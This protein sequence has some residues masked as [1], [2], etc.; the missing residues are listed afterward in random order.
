MLSGLGYNS[1]FALIIP[2][3]SD[4]MESKEV[5]SESV[6]HNKFLSAIRLELSQLSP[7]YFALVM[8]TGIVSIAAHLIGFTEIAQLLFK[9]NIVAYLLLV[10][11]FILRFIFFNNQF[12]RGL[13]SHQKSPG[14]FT[15][16]AGS[17]VLG[18]QFVLLSGNYNIALLLYYFAF[19]F[20]L[21]FIYYFFTVITIKRN[22][23]TLNKGLNGLW[24]LIV[25]S[26]QSLSILGIE[27][28]KYLFFSAEISFFLSLAL[29]LLGCLFYVIIISMIV[30]RLSFFPIQAEDFAPPYWISM[31]AVAITTLAGTSLMLN[32]EASLFLAEFQG[33]IKGM[34]LLF[35]AIG[36]WWIPLII[37]LGIWRHIY[38]HI[39]F[40]YH[41]Q[42]WGMVFPLGMYT[43]CSYRLAQ[44]LGFNFIFSIADV[45]IYFAFAAW[46]ITALGLLY[47]LSS[48]LIT[49]LK[50]N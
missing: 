25:V 5:G 45:F 50:S 42:Y 27:V 39:P 28:H 26:T 40:I 35:W 13:T 36:T 43:V 48:R 34:T 21:F 31:G 20:W 18:S 22:K 49:T 9:L 24:L 33:F 29:F 30:Y 46:G 3:S 12:I 11:L 10:L 44:A 4:I 23:P 37:I 6:V 14:F 16:V 32:P 19:I 47:K 7:S 41:P 17:G 2:K 15:V 1:Y 38:R 8:A